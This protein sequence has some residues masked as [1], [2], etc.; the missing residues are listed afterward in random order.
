MKGICALA[1][2]ETRDTRL[3]H[4]DSCI[5]AD[6]EAEDDEQFLYGEEGRIG[7]VEYVLIRLW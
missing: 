1:T 5:M 6:N 3:P 2:K 4:V 7:A